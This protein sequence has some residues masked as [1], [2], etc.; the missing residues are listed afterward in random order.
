RTFRRNRFSRDAEGCRSGARYSG[1]PPR[2]SETR[3]RSWTVTYCPSDALL[4]QLNC[5]MSKMV[6]AKESGSTLI[7]GLGLE[8]A[9]L[10]DN[11]NP[12]ADALAFYK[13]G[14]I[15]KSRTILLAAGYENGEDPVA[16][17][18]FLRLFPNDNSVADRLKRYAKLLA[19]TDS[20]I[21]S[22]I[23]KE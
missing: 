23:A 17:A 3:R 10:M 19:D 16:Q 1:S 5:F 18:E 4:G 8:R 9:C 11:A 6:L 2:R 7:R 21:R 20:K 12:V 14:E 22:S 13:A 15:E